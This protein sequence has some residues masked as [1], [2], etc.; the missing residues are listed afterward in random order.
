MKTVIIGNGILALTTAFRLGKESGPNDEIIVIGK[1]SR[2]GSA[3]LAAAAMLNSFAEVEA[4]SLDHDLEL[5]RFELSRL[6]T[7]MWPKFIQE[8]LET[9]GGGLLDGCYGL[10]TYIINNTASDHLDDEN[11]LA[12]IDALKRFNE[13]HQDIPPSE[14]PNYHPS[15]RYRA[16]RAIY[17]P[18]EGW[19]NPCLVIE[20][21]DAALKHMPR[22]KIIESE[23]EKLLASTN[24]S[25]K[26]AELV[27]GNHIEGDKFLLATGA[28]ASKILDKSALGIV[29]QR[30]FYGV[31]VSLAVKSPQ[32]PH[33]KCIRT[34]NRGLACGVYTVPFFISPDQPHDSVVL[35]ASN[36]ISHVPHEGARVESVQ[37]ILRSAMEQVNTNFYRASVTK[38]NVGWRPTS[39]DT[40]PVI[41]QTS[42]PNLVIATGTKRDGFHLSPV[43]S[44]KLAA[45]LRNQAVD[46]ERFKAFSPERKLIRTLS[47]TAA[48]EKTVKHMLSAAYQHGYSP[49]IG[50]M[51]EQLKETY[52]TD[53]ERL[54]DKVG[55][56]DWG[57]PPEMVD[58]YRYGHINS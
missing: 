11:Y 12:I 33:K 27:D 56:H 52:R 32:Y 54:H 50:P 28:T 29:V 39:S 43:L 2:P 17:I 55:A 22:V 34:P 40:F 31:G 51:N 53:L 47:R 35:G 23:V 46:D 38:I 6:A 16:G 24:G 48:I 25:I 18:N 42:I 3:T 26:A 19:L 15:E 45:I 14:I 8:I 1:P 44:K 20:V 58:M 37:S 36:L 49:S 21:L 30:I 9:T 10:G 13:P 5:Y 57:I 7:R 41:G 4:G